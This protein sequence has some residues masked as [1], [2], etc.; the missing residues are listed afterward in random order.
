MNGGTQSFLIVSDGMFLTCRSGVAQAYSP[1]KP[2]PGSNGAD[3]FPLPDCHHPRCHRRKG[4]VSG[5]M[6]LVFTVS[7]SPFH[8]H[9]ILDWS[10]SSS[11][12]PYYAN[13]AC[14]TVTSQAAPTLARGV[15]A[16]AHP[17]GEAE[18]VGSPPARAQTCPAPRLCRLR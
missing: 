10:Y 7:E 11:R 13:N 4:K 12:K 2:W 3:G 8:A 17:P 1:N 16:R 15:S 14:M 5:L 9:A 6:L 18:G